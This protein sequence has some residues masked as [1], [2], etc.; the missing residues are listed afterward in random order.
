MSYG[1]APIDPDNNRSDLRPSG[2]GGGVSALTAG[3]GIEF[4][5]PTGIGAVI[6]SSP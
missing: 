1:N 4:V 6:I 3:V 5:P 2:G